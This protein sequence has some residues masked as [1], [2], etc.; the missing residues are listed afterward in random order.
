MVV[1]AETGTTNLASALGVPTVVLMG[2]GDFARFLPATSRDVIAC[3]PLACYGCGWKCTFSREHCVRDLMP[4][5][6]AA[7][8]AAALAGPS[9][10]SRVFVPSPHRIARRRDLPPPGDVRQWLGTDIADVI[11]VDAGPA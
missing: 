1:G 10:K 4:D 6:L 2:G 3:L 9:E 7:A 8:F 11:E 5:V